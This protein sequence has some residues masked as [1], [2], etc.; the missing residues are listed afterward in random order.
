MK[1][2]VVSQ[3]P[4]SQLGSVLLLVALPAI[5]SAANSD[6]HSRFGP[7][8]FRL[9]I[10]VVSAK[11]GGL[12]AERWRQPPVL[13]ELVAGIA[14]GNLLPLFFSVEGTAVVRELRSR[15]VQGA[16]PVMRLARAYIGLPAAE[17]N[18]RLVSLP[19]VP[20][21]QTFSCRHREF[22]RTRCAIGTVSLVIRVIACSVSN[23]TR[24]TYEPTSPS[25][26]RAPAK[27]VRASL[28]LVGSEAG[29]VRDRSARRATVPCSGWRR[30]PMRQRLGVQISGTT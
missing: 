25:L 7:I 6:A 19:R 18:G 12:L 1:R 15:L 26:Y 14:L 23:P 28:T 5:A 29:L 9:A 24:E 16:Y 4:L 3:V 30:P 21:W 2:H 20:R 13:G 27:L 11:V 17:V 22:G 8:L 10:L